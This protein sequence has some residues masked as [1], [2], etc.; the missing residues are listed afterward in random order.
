MYIYTDTRPEFSSVGT[1]GFFLH[2]Q[3]PDPESDLTH[4]RTVSLLDVQF[5]TCKLRS[6][7]SQQSAS[8]LAALPCARTLGCSD[9]YDAR[10]SSHEHGPRVGDFKTETKCFKITVKT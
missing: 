1:D 10:R 6:L 3:R 7:Y 8:I 2:R 5:I 4:L 9:L